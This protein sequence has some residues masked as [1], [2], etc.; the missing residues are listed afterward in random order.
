M[1]LYSRCL[2]ALALYV[3]NFVI[4]SFLHYCDVSLVF[5]YCANA[6]IA[7]DF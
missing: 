3:C 6:R 5:D 2:V 4:I 7:N 1:L